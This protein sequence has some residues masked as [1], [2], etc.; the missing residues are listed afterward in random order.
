MNEKLT[1]QHLVEILAA[2]TG[3]DRTQIEAFLRELASLVCEGVFNEQA[4]QIKGIGAFKVILTKERKNFDANTQE[5]VTVPPQHKLAFVPA[6][7]FSKRV[8]RQFESFPSE[9]RVMKSE[10]PAGLHLSGEEETE[11]DETEEI[12]EKITDNK[13]TEI[14]EEKYYPIPPV[15]VSVSGRTAVDETAGASDLLA[16]GQTLP[17]RPFEDLGDEETQYAGG[18][19]AETPDEETQLLSCPLEDLRDEET[20]YAGGFGGE[21]PDEA[22][23]LLGCP[24]EDSRDEETQYA[25]GF[26]GEKPDEAA[27]LVGMGPENT[28]KEETQLAGGYREEPAWSVS[29]NTGGRPKKSRFNPTQIALAIILLL[30]LCGG[31]GYLL[32][33]RG[34]GLFHRDK[35]GWISGESFALPGDS[36]ALEQAR[37]KASVA[38][39]IDPE[40]VAATD[41]VSPAGAAESASPQPKPENAAKKTPANAGKKTPGSRTGKSA[42]AKTPATASG[43]SSGKVLARVTMSS[44]NR[45]TLLA[46]KYYGDKI[47]WV[48]IY[49]FNKA[50]IG[51]NPDLVPVGMELRIPAKEV[52]GIDANN[53]AS[54]EKARQLQA[55]IKGEIN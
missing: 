11:E 7:S 37:R 14:M 31:L 22:T 52:Y 16:N 51:S 15:P 9:S 50:K 5:T 33:T 53:A 42:S 4:V 32:V 12:E 47:F 41:S 46:L 8:N 44:G 40:N 28:H 19:G 1:S 36:A 13:K 27:Q 20:Q 17:D 55:K 39:E 18:F 24:L 25:G 49:D 10:L 29:G 54:R 23:Q 35:S 2:Q 21:K 38:S 30:V 34:S 3:R 26:G 43:T 45:L 6:E 48:Y